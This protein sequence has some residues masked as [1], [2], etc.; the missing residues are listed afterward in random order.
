MM[1]DFFHAKY[2]I[3][4]LLTG[5]VLSIYGLSQGILFAEN[6][7]VQAGLNALRNEANCFHM[8]A[9]L[10]TNL[11]LKRPNFQTGVVYIQWGSD[12]YGRCN[13]QWHQGLD[14]IHTQTGARWLE[15]PITFEQISQTTT[16]ITTL[17]T[18][19]S[20]ESFREGIADAHAM[21]YSVFVVPLIGISTGTG[22]W[23][24]AIHFTS[25]AMEQQ[26]FD[27]YWQVFRPYVV[28][29]AQGDADQ[30]AIGTED[31]W[32][33]RN[34]PASLWKHFIAQVRSVF[35]GML[36]YDMNWSSITKPIPSWLADTNISMVGVSEYIP[37]TDKREET[38]TENVTALWH[39]KVQKEID[40][41][42]SRLKK[43]VFLSE[44][45]YRNSTDALYNPWEA[46]TPSPHSP[47]QQAVACNAA[48]TNILA[49]PHIH[50]VYFWGWENVGLFTLRNSP[51]VAA[52]HK[53]YTL[54]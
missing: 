53:W 22:R 50:G 1:S 17:P 40:A 3:F 33:E 51:A 48:L 14:D 35:S 26:W 6:T 24:G 28:A 44:I 23:S 27:N 5:I 30:I 25:M 29:A 12:G 7:V 39:S 32:L 2:R 15:L 21:G 47:S 46:V 10:A 45:G 52:L 8:H 54:S 18:T 43:P 31:E 37:L 42:A 38:S 34:V 16:H 9:P 11:H 13:G 4:L 49:D 36:T 20:V 41:F 19:P